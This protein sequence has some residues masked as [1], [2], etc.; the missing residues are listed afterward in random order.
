MV[1]ECDVRPTADQC[2]SLLDQA[3]EA[4]IDPLRSSSVAASQTK[5][6][7]QDEGNQDDLSM[8][9]A[10]AFTESENELYKAIY[11]YL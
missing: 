5:S 8:M 2:L 10:N 7:A 3:L 1:I 4:T 6:I 11:G 9:R